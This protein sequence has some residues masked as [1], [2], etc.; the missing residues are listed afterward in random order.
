MTFVLWSSLSLV[1]AAVLL[2]AHGQALAIVYLASTVVT[3]AYH[4]SRERRWRR[5]DHALAW[6]VIGANSW[7]ALCTN[8]FAWTCAGLASVCVA[9]WFYA[10]AK[11]ARYAFNHGWWHLWSG[12]GCFAFAMGALS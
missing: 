3:I 12:L 5:L 2:A 6:G 11:R 4:R 1:P 7:L 10:R 9:L 8:S